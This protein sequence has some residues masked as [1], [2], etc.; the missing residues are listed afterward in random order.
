MQHEEDKKRFTVLLSKFTG[1]KENDIAQFLKTNSARTLLESP[2]MIKA[3]DIQRRK[4]EELKELRNL[5]ENLKGYE[6]K[7]QMTSTYAAMDYLKNFMK[8]FQDKER[9]ACVFMDTK[10]NIISTKIMIEGTINQSPVYPREIAKEALLSNAAG[11]ILCHNHP[12][13]DPMPSQ[14]D[15]AITVSIAD[16]LYTV[17]VKCLDHVIVGG[18]NAYSFADQGIMPEPTQLNVFREPN[19]SYVVSEKKSGGTLDQII[20]KS[21]RELIEKQKAQNVK[22]NSHNIKYQI[23]R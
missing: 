8:D 19:Q 12:S 22:A 13:G 14:P 20:E 3:T 9:F 6:K 5:I 18:N 7:Y 16:A 21:K 2:T 17:Q 1:I 11:V 15:K 4:V 23:G 10:N